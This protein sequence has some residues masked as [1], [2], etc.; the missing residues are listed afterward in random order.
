LT[1]PHMLAPEP[2]GI[3]AAQPSVEQHAEPYT[4]SRSDGPARLVRSDVFLRPRNEAL[5][6]LARQV[7]H[8]NGRINL[9]QCCLFGPTEQ[10]PH[11]VEEMARLVW[12]L[13]APIPSGLDRRGGDLRVGLMPRSLNYA[14][15][16]IFAPAP[17]RG[18]KVAPS[19]GLTISRHE[20][21]QRALQRR[22][23]AGRHD[24]KS[25]AIFGFKFWRRVVC[26]N[27][28]ARS[29]IES[30]VPN[31]FTVAGDLSLQVRR[32]RA[33]HQSTISLASRASS[34]L[35]IITTILPSVSISTLDL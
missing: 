16:D 1:P 33:W 31:T 3:A 14:L 8:A 6:A 28:Y 29:A 12:R 11:G 17:R 10:S 18:G 21:L 4:L 2:H 35:A 7:R 5:S 20:P 24:S 27:S 23:L 15:E 13:C 32:A 25:G 34:D 19:C 30:D 26:P 22:G 9:D